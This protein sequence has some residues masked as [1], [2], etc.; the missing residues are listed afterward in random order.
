[1]RAFVGAIVE[2]SEPTS[3]DDERD[4]R[5]N[6]YGTTVDLTLYRHG[7]EVGTSTLERSGLHLAEV[8]ERGP[9]RAHEDTTQAFVTVRG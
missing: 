8:I 9:E 5:P 3:T 7:V 2:G 1:M 4:P 6:A